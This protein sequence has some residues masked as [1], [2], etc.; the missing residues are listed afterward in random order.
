MGASTIVVTN[1]TTGNLSLVGDEGKPRV[2]ISNVGGSNY[3]SIS[4]TSVVGN[5]LLCDTLSAWITSGK[6]SVTRGGVTVTAAQMAAFKTAMTSDIYDADLDDTVDS[7]EDLSAGE[8]VQVVIT[9]TGGSAGS[10]AGTI[11]VQVNDLSGTAITRAVTI[12]L[13]SSL[14][15]LAGPLAATGTAFFGAATTGTLVLG[16]G[17]L[18]AL[19]TTD[20]TGLYE[21]ALSDAADETAYFSARTAPGGSAS[22]AAG[23]VVVGCIPDA[24]TWAP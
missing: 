11:S 20:A 6:A 14:T 7:A 21:G 5:V 23:C 18:T 1:A 4:L 3:E 12:A 2:D 22:L 19:V 15:E 8:L 24:A 17:T 16:S 10:T 13:D 9:A